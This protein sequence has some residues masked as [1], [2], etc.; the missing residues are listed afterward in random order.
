[1]SP[2]AYQKCFMYRG[3]IRNLVT[4]QVKQVNTCHTIIFKQNMDDDSEPES[5]SSGHNANTYNGS[6]T[7]NQKQEHHSQE[8]ET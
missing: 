6:S 8:L 5:G 3:R 2:D 4:K 7:S 1:M